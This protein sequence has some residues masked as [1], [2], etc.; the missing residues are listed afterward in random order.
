MRSISSRQGYFQGQI[1]PR[2]V[3]LPRL[4]DPYLCN[5]KMKYRFKHKHK[6]TME[7]ELQ[8]IDNKTLKIV[9]IQNG[10]K[11]AKAMVAYL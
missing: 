7:I 8:F 9:Y 11:L 10:N 3:F 2:Q 1:S 5:I 6:A 4:D